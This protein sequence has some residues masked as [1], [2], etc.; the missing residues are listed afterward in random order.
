[1][2]TALWQWHSSHPISP[3]FSV[4][5]HSTCSLYMSFFLSFW[6]VATF[7]L[8]CKNV[9]CVD[10]CFD[11]L[12]HCTQI[13]CW[14]FLFLYGIILLTDFRPTIHVKEIILIIWIFSLFTEEIRQVLFLHFYCLLLCC[15]PF[16]HCRGRTMCLWLIAT[17]LR[18]LFETHCKHK[19]TRIKG[20]Y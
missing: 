2:I 20:L 4:R 3:H 11:C 14:V 12:C 6:I 16:K 15:A 17:F 10:R 18:F 9:L 1:V 5:M 7:L 8:D 19:W 13:S